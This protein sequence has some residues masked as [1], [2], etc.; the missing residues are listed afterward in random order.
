MLRR[1]GPD[2]ATTR[3][4][5]KLASNP[6][7]VIRRVTQ[8]TADLAAIAAGNSEIEPPRRDRRFADTA[9]KGNPMLR[10]TVQ[11]YL[12]LGKTAEGL[13]DDADLDW[14]D[15][16]KLT[17]VLTNLIAASAPSNN[18]FLNPL[19]WKA[20]IDTGGLSVV[21]GARAFAGDMASAPHIPTMVE[22]DAFTVGKDIGITPGAVVSRTDIYEL[23]QYKPSTPTVHQYPLLMVPPMP[24]VTRRH[25]PVVDRGSGGQTRER[26]GEWGRRV[27]HPGRL[28]SGHLS[29]GGR[30]AV[31]ERDPHG[32][33]FGVHR[34]AHGRR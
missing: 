27:A 24:E 3:W 10:R 18:P 16:T 32:G 7:V 1:F 23:I 20:F 6:G 11:T 29:I 9:W 31:L 14:K 34:A 28:S 8:L 17:F 19:A 33:P 2:S 12:A 30:R 26:R 22:P 21:R 4:A 5:L 15:N 13:L 25:G